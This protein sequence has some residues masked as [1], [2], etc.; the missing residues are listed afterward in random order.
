MRKRVILLLSVCWLFWAGPSHADE[1]A[2]RISAYVD[3]V[4]K[5]FQNSDICETDCASSPELKKTLRDLGNEIFDFRIM[6]RMSLGHHWQ[7]LTEKQQNEFVDLYTRLLET[8]YF[9]KIVEHFEDI[10]GYSSDKVR[11]VDETVFSS[12]KAEVKTVIQHEGEHIPVDYRLVL[13]NGDWKIYDVYVEGVSLINNYRK[14]FHEILV[15]KTAQEML[16][17]LREKVQKNPDAKQ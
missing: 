1:P 11:V 3:R 5:A 14:Q 7:K 9:G 10:K 4:L 16:Q 15:K 6:S 2:E 17:S 13:R 8:N 12:R